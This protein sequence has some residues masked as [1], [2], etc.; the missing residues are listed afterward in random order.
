MF[1]ANLENEVLSIFQNIAP[2]DTGNLAFNAIQKIK[3][4]NGFAILLIGDIAPYAIELNSGNW[5]QGRFEGFFTTDSKNA[6]LLHLRGKGGYTNSIGATQEQLAI[7]AQDNPAR[8]KL[9]I[10]NISKSEI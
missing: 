4:P 7:E 5:L 9:L 10:D 1:N 2:R 6:G 8:Q 3:I